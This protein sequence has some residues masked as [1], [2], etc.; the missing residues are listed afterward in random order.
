MEAFIAKYAITADNAATSFSL[1]AIPMAQPT[2]KIN[3]RLSNN[4]LPA[5][6]KTRRNIFKNVPSPKIACNP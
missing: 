1:D 4:A 3:G 5:L 2:A 6:L